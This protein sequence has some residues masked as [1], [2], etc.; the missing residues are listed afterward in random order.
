MPAVKLPLCIDFACPKCFL[1][2]TEPL[3]SKVVAKKGQYLK[4]G[5]V[6][7]RLPFHSLPR[8]GQ[9]TALNHLGWL[10]YDPKSRVIRSVSL[11]DWTGL[12][13]IQ[14][15]WFDQAVKYWSLVTSHINAYSD[16]FISVIKLCEH[17]WYGGVISK[18]AL[19]HIR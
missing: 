2:I 14:W 6:R 8:S 5:H 10:Y 11:I 1:F 12:F 4:M 13:V 16:D 17:A 19:S 3:F 7:V 18:C 15:A 9:L